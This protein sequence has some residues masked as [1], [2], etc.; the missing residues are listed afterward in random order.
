MRKTGATNYNKL[1]ECDEQIR[2]LE[3]IIRVASRYGDDISF[4]EI[5][6]SK[7]QQKKKELTQGG[8]TN[9]FSSDS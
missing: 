2:Q 5:E 4:Y 7:M 3:N 9:V 8:G 6:L 1:R